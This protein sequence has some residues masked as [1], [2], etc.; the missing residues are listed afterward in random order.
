[1]DSAP[2]IAPPARHTP[3]H[4]RYDAIHRALLTG[5]LSNVASKTETYEYLGPRNIRMSIFPG[6][7]LFGQKQKWIV[8][9][10]LVETTKLYARTCAAVQPQWIERAADHLVDRSY[11]DPRWDSKSA[12][13]VATEKV[14]LHGL[15]LIPART[16][17]FG[18]INPRLSRE[19]FIHHALVM[20]DYRTS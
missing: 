10:E 9:G 6:S 18:P 14:S 3:K 11:S 1:M 13:V 19:L 12:S 8:A 7:S 2:L 20:G 4:P 15:V 17:P 5:L 16:I